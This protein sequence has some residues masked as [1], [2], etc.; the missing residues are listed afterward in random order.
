[1]IWGASFRTACEWNNNALKT[2]KVT[3]RM[4]SQPVS[5]LG[6]LQHAVDMHMQE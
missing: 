1:M 6:E 2:L 3:Q 4:E 5:Q